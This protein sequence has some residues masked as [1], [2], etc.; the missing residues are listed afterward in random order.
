MRVSPV[1]AASKHPSWADLATLAV[2]TDAD[3]HPPAPP[4]IRA[5]T[6]AITTTR[7]VPTDELAMA[8]RSQ[9]VSSGL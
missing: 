7:M 9:K 6:A 3:A 4:K 8:L 2:E 5:V 1:D